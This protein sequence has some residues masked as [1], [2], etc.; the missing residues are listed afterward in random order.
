[1]NVPFQSSGAE[2]RIF[3]SK[4]FFNVVLNLNAV[5]MGFYDTLLCETDDPM[6]DIRWRQAVP[7]VLA[8]MKKRRDLL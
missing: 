5:Q 6:A 2:E 4:V 1:M 3:Y 7:S 8:E